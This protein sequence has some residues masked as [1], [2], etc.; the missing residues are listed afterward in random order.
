MNRPFRLVG[1]QLNVNTCQIWPHAIRDLR[2]RYVG[3]SVHDGRVGISPYTYFR[4]RPPSYASTGLLNSRHNS[5]TLNSGYTQLM[6]HN[7]AYDDRFFALDGGDRGT[8][9]HCKRGRM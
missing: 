8:A 1:D 7:L 6:P 9:Q 3:A 4:E 2:S 5:M